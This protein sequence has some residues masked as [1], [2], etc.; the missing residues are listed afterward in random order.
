MKIN[1]ASIPDSITYVCKKE[2]SV[3]VGCAWDIDHYDDNNNDKENVL[4]AF[5]IETGNKSSEKTAKKWTRNNTDGVLHIFKNEPIKNVRV[6]SLESRG[7][8]GRAYKALID[9]FYIDLRED[10]LMDTILKSGISKGGI[11]GGDYIWVKINSQIKLVRI[12]S[13]IY[14]LISEFH[15]K[16]DIKPISKN[17]LEIGGIYQN[18]KKEK[19]I[20]IGYGQNIVFKDNTKKCDSITFDFEYSKKKNVLVFF[21]YYNFQSDIKNEQDFK[22]SC[23]LTTAD[24]NFRIRLVNDN[25]YIEKVGNISVPTNLINTIRERALSKIRQDVLEFTD[26]ISPKKNYNK[27]N[28]SI[29]RSNIIYYSKFL[30]LY[31]TGDDSFEIFDVKKLLTFS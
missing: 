25:N 3:N 4:P 6:L 13:E 5:P 10:V 15:A 23:K 17:Q 19:V 28:S 9:R 31:Q 11:L 16:K 26:N 22:K 12:G 30:N 20:F 27:I 14:D 21:E 2:L 24:G 29:L 1:S 18:R 7:E 8:G